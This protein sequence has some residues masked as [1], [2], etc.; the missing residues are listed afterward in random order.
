[1]LGIP[2]LRDVRQ[3]YHLTSD[4]FLMMG[5]ETGWTGEIR[6]L[7]WRV[8]AKGVECARVEALVRAYRALA[9]TVERTLHRKAL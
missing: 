6:D 2:L 8:L 1:M 9:V 7:A 3:E 4:P 5:L